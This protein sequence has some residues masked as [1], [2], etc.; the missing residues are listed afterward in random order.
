MRS[1]ST[2]LAGCGNAG[3]NLGIRSRPGV[4]FAA[5]VIYDRDQNGVPSNPD[6]ALAGVRVFLKVP[7]GPDTLAVN[8]TDASG[9]AAF[10]NIPTGPYA[11]EVEASV[12]G[13]SLETVLTR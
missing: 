10:L 9:R 8:T 2:A 4:G 11:V 5:T 6:S 3:E 7:G 12:L 1:A 13:D